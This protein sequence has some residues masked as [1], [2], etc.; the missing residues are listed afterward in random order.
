MYMMEKKHRRAVLIR[1]RRLLA[2]AVCMVQDIS[3]TAN[4]LPRASSSINLESEI[5]YT[6]NQGMAAKLAV[7]IG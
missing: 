3:S 6:F 7:P 2:I 1:T 4:T 5:K